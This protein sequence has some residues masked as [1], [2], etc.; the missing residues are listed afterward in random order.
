MSKSYIEEWDI[1]LLRVL[2]SS[3]LPSRLIANPNNELEK[4]ELEKVREAIKR[5]G[6]TQEGAG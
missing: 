1:T 6:K 4:E 3:I 5:R 2:E